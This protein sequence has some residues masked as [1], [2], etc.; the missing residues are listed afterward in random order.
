L[1]RVRNTY[2][3]QL[4]DICGTMEGLDGRIYP[5][6]SKYAHLNEKA[7]LLGDPCGRMGNGKLHEAM[8]NVQITQTALRTVLLHAN[9]I[10]SEMQIE[11]D[12]AEAQCDITDMVAELQE[13]LADFVAD[14]HEQIGTTRAI[15]SAIQREIDAVMGSMSLMD[16]ESFGCPLSAALAGTALAIQT[17]ANVTMT[18]K[19]FEI[20][21][22][23][24]EI[25]DEQAEVAKQ[26]TLLEACERLKVDSGAAIQRLSLQL[27]ESELEALRADYQMRLAL[28]EIVELANS[29]QRWQAQQREAEQLLINVEAARNDPNV[30]IYRNDAVINADIAFDDA[31]REVYRTTRV[32]EYYTSQSYA[33]REQLFLIRM[34][35]AGEYNLENYL[36]ELQNE[37]FTFE[38]QFGVP[39]NRVQILSLRD[40][41]LQIPY[42]D[43][44]GAPLSQGERI[45]RMRDRLKD[46]ALLDSSGYLTIPF[47]TE[48]NV[49]SPLTRNH[50]VRHVE[51][52]IVGS[53]VG[54]TLGRVYLRQIGTGIIRSVNDTTDYYVFP[55]RT[56]VINTYF[57]G[58]R[59]FDPEIYRNYRLRDRA[60]ANTLWE[61]VI[62]Q[63]DEEV[64]KDID[65]QSLSDIRLLIYYN[66]FTA[67]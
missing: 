18:A 10:V 7:S 34:V 60:L 30:R 31:I 36:N 21:E 32:F 29:A 55:E 25:A 9:N 26:V 53:D 49:L 6:I 56:G 39:D 1:V 65:L 63:R 24:R 33:R 11:T 2:E 20:V 57:N 64:N 15:M 12:R 61:F 52:D 54:D 47:S 28:S 66:D 22:K 17:I 40:D 51:A 41:L 4:S 67:Y 37:F 13:D 58:N 8:A 48:L 44:E 19:E 23:E 38:E 27:G 42:L 62:N 16:C 3:N 43:D 5:A 45:Q 50:K 46:V 59:V 14:R 35:T